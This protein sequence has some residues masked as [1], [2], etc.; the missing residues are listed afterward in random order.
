MRQHFKNL[1]DKLLTMPDKAQAIAQ[2]IAEAQ[3][4]QARSELIKIKKK[5]FKS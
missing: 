2:A 1:I 5:Y 4:Q 3:N